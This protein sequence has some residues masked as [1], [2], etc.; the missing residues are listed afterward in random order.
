MKRPKGSLVQMSLSS[1]LYAIK[2]RGLKKMLAQK[3]APKVTEWPSYD[4]F[5]KVTPTHIFWKGAKG[6][7]REIF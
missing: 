7:L 6:G 5:G 3:A 1:Y 2:V 4:S